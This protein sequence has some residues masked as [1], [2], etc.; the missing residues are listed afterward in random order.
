[1]PASNIPHCTLNLVNLVLGV[2]AFHAYIW[3]LQTKLGT[4]ARSPDSTAHI[5]A[6]T[7]SARCYA[8]VECRVISGWLWVQDPEDQAP[9]GYRTRGTQRQGQGTRQSTTHVDAKRAGVK[10]AAQLRGVCTLHSPT[11]TPQAVQA[12]GIPAGIER[13]GP[14]RAW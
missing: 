12:G 8:R 1:M 11:R 4:L 9:G 13:C 6:T 5:T 10:V 2:L 14:Q 3:N 7:I